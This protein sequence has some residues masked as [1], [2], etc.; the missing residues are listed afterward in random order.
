MGSNDRSCGQRLWDEHLSRW[1][2]DFAN[3]LSQQSELALYRALGL[4]LLGLSADRAGH[5]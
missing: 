1:L 4:Q 5:E 2:A 3:D